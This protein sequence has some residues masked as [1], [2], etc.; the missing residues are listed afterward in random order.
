MAHTRARTRSIV[1]VFAA[2]HRCVLLP[3]D[4][5][6]EIARHLRGE[7]SLWTQ[8][9]VFIVPPPGYDLRCCTIEYLSAYPRRWLLPHAR[10][11]NAPR[12]WGR[13]AAAAAGFSPIR[14]RYPFPCWRYSLRSAREDV[15]LLCGDAQQPRRWSFETGARYVYYP[16]PGSVLQGP[17]PYDTPP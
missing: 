5:R 7:P 6:L 14:A 16:D 2:R 13:S 9:D 8:G 12:G 10:N 4:L 11:V 17:E 3:D 15:A 1:L